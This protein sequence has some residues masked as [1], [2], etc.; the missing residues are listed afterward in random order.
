MNL[1]IDKL[2]GHPVA[3][4]ST[5]V[6]V[7]CAVVVLMRGDVVADLLQEEIELIAQIRMINDNVIDSNNLDQ[8]VESLQSYVAAIDRRLFNRSERSINTNFFYSFEDKLDI[9]IADVSQLTIEEPALI[10]DGPNELSLYSGIVYEIKV[11]GTFKE[12][13]GFMYEIQ[14]VDALMRIANFEVFIATAQS[15]ASESLAAK[16]HVVVLA[17]KN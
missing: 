5:V 10:K 9:T 8:D 2:K 16:L 3:L 13:L 17:E 7:A 6:F 12:I 1:I 11:G 14:H 4:I 15:A